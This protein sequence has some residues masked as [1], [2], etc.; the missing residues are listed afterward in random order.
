MNPRVLS[1]SVA[2]TL[3]TCLCASLSA[4]SSPAPAPKVKPGVAVLGTRYEVWLSGHPSAN[5]GGVSGYG[6]AVVVLGKSTPQ[7]TDVRQQGGR[8]VS[9][10]MNL[11]PRTQLA[12]AEALVRAQLPTDIRQ[13]ASWEGTYPASAGPVAHCEFVDFQSATLARSLGVPP[14][15]GSTPNIGVFLAERTARSPGSPSIATVNSVNVSTTPAAFLQN[16]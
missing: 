2:A 11:P 4:C 5:V 1:R 10:H 12:A 6:P 3:A 15:L 13:T 8:V 7:F 9:L 14:P 16:C